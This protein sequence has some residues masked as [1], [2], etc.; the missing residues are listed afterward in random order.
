MFG[1]T[2]SCLPHSIQ[3]YFPHTFKRTL[4][5]YYIIDVASS[6]GYLTKINNTSQYALSIAPS[7]APSMKR[8]CMN[9][10]KSVSL[11]KENNFCDKDNFFVFCVRFSNWLN[12]S[13]LITCYFCHFFVLMALLS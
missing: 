2:L 5:R 3:L 6:E 1:I 11:N 9:K 7:G 10:M 8:L 13:F 12:R 4:F